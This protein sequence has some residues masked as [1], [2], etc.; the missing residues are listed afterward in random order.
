MSLVKLL[1]DVFVP[2]RQTGYFSQL[3]EI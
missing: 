1:I 3:Y 2:K